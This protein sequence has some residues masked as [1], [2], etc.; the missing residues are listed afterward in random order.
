[1]PIAGGRGTHRQEPLP[2]EEP[3]LSTPQPSQR[4][5]RSRS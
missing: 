1:M 5:R 2:L 3:L 4:R